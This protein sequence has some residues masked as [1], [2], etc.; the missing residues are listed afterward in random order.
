MK[1]KG[2]DKTFGEKLI[3]MDFEDFITKG[4]SVTFAEGA[5]EHLESC[6]N[7]NSIAIAKICKL[8]FKRHLITQDD[9]QDIA[10]TYLESFQIYGD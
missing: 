3:D 4:L 10:K 1:I 7:N 5:I 2:I 8:L 9:I 6:I